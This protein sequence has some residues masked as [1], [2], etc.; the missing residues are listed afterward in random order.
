MTTLETKKRL[1]NLDL[2]W[3][4]KWPPAQKMKKDYKCFK[5]KKTTIKARLKD[6]NDHQRNKCLETRKFEEKKLQR[7]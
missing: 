4:W 3:G 7:L 2:G 5:D 6:Q 1:W